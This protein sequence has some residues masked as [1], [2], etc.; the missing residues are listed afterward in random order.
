MFQSIGIIGAGLMGRTI[1]LI[2]AE[3]GLQVRLTDTAG[4]MLDQAVAWIRKETPAHTYVKPTSSLG[5][6]ADCDL[7]L[8]TIVESLKPKR[9]VLARVEDI[10]SA[11]T[12]LAS[13]ASVIPISQIAAGLEQPQRMC[14]IH[15]CHPARFRPAVEIIAGEATSAAT[16]A[17]AFDYARRI[18]RH[19]VRVKDTTG[20]VVNRAL[21]PYMN[22]AQVLL[23]EGAGIEEVDRAATTFG[24]PWGPLTQLDE[25]GLDTIV[26]GAQ[27]MGRAY[28]DRQLA[29]ELLADLIDMGR[30]GCKTKAGFYTYDA[31]GTRTVAAEIDKLIAKHRK[32]HRD[33]SQAEIAE[34]LFG[35]MGEE[36]QRIVA[37]GVVAAR[38]DVETALCVGL[39][40]P[41]DKTYVL[42]SAR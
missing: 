30:Y 31:L 15:F 33:I 2:N 26:R 36:S 23:L 14:G 34:R 39:G 28:P 22:E 10:V 35:R 16:I 3:H 7:I 18:G 21:H 40:Y 25:I 29:G 13:N 42:W 32:L 4:D 1:A 11:S 8:E 5:D 38:S 19:G 41:R 24:M 17:T 37:E 20:F 9:Q 12:V 27:I 6:F